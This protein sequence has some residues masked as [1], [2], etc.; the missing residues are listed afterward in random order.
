MAMADTGPKSDRRNAAIIVGASGRLGLG[1]AREFAHR[2]WHVT[3]TARNPAS[4][5]GLAAVD[6]NSHKGAD[7]NQ[8]R[9]HLEAIWQEMKASSCAA[10]K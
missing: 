7:K 2:G 5:I 4:A 9:P 1:L 8:N 3:A 10:A 6:A